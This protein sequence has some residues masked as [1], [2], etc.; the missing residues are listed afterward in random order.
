MEN[1]KGRSN[2]YSQW[3]LRREGCLKASNLPE[4]LEDMLKEQK[5]ID[6][7]ECETMVGAAVKEAQQVF[8]ERACEWLKKNT[9]LGTHP[10]ELNEFIKAMEK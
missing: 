7:K 2:S 4:F 3:I 10:Y 1:I 9:F 8:L 6:D 5:K